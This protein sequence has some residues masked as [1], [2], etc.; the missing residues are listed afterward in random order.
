M[1]DSVSSGSPAPLTPRET[2]MYEQE[3]KHSA[4]LFQQA[5]QSYTTSDNPYQQ[6]EFQNVMDKAMDVINNT[7][8]ELNQKPL[9]AQSS[10]IQKDY[11]AFTDKPEDKATVNQL[12]Q[13]LDQARKAIT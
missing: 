1:T 11:D 4:E 6:K 12:N 3:Y 10:K 13:D 2:K 9:L 5:L 8:R 7:A